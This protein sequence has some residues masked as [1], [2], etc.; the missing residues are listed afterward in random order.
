MKLPNKIKPPV[1]LYHGGV[2]GLMPGDYVLPPEQTGA[3]HCSNWMKEGEHNPH[4]T[5]R[6]YLTTDLQTAATWA[7]L[8]GV[9]DV[10]AVVPVGE[11][12]IDPDCNTP[13]LSWQ[14]PK[15]RILMCV[16]RGVRLG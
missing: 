13:G 8:R 5:D 4:R 14:A 15:A 2:T 10:Y 11:L 3:D 6:V 16:Q 7:A 12:E 9:G 1:E